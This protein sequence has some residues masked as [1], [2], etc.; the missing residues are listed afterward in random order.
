MQKTCE[1]TQT[2]GG[3]RL[4]APH[5]LPDDL[6]IRVATNN[7]AR[8][9]AR[10]SSKYN[11]VWGFVERVRQKTNLTIGGSNKEL[12]RQLYDLLVTNP[13]PSNG[14]LHT[15]CLMTSGKCN[16]FCEQCYTDQTAHQGAWRIYESAI[17]EAKSYGAQTVYIAG[18]GEP[19]LDDHIGNIIRLA[20]ELGMDVLMF[21]NGL[22]FCHETV[23]Y[24]RM[25]ARIMERDGEVSAQEFVR[26]LA[27][28]PVHLY[29]KMHSANRTINSRLCGLIGRK[30]DYTYEVAEFNGHQMD[31]PTPLLR[32]PEWKFPIE[33]LGFDAMVVKEN[34]DELLNV[35]CP[36]SQSM[37]LALYCEP[38]IPSGRILGDPSPTPEQLNALR[39]SGYL[40]RQDCTLNKLIGKVVI[41]SRGFVSPILAF[42]WQQ[43]AERP[44]LL[45]DPERGFMEQRDYHSLFQILRYQAGCPCAMGN[46]NLERMLDEYAP[47]QK[48]EA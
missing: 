16:L 2:F 21:S 24:R 41:W 33:R 5:R 11:P 17:R 48:S 35:V 9:L 4:L 45:Y 30:F 39:Q 10:D 18:E 23:G 37:G 1:L 14:V 22:Q 32:L 31:V 8:D 46:Q 19:F 7:V 27:Q 15:I 20:T 28:Y 13:A 36:W 42:T 29:L 40:V 6:L 12:D 34:A 43:L 38:F 3:A 26:W 44:A 47:R 25:R